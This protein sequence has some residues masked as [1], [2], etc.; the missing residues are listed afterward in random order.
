[1]GIDVLVEVA[2]EKL[3]V[4]FDAPHFINQRMG[5]REEKN[6]NHT[7]KIKIQKTG[8]RIGKDNIVFV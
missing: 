7:G 6:G 4:W 2:R 3:Y 5:L 1:L 8:S